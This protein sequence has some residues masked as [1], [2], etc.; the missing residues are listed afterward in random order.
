MSR[1]IPVD[2]TVLCPDGATCHHEC[3]RACFRVLTC[4]PLS[5]YRY[6]G[7]AMDTWPAGMTE[8]HER[9]IA[10]HEIDPD[11]TGGKV[12]AGH[13]STSR[14]AASR[15]RR[16]TQLSALL[17]VVVTA[18]DDGVT[19]FEATSPMRTMLGRTD[20]SRNQVATRMGEL[21]ERGLVT[22]RIAPGQTADRWHY[23]YRYVERQTE[24][25]NTA[26]VWWPTPAGIAERERLRHVLPA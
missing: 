20:L 21:A 4:S 24:G 18:G 12:G 16:G 26:C 9:A 15:V 13:P 14:R 7:R 23:S 6:K 22:R 1:R 17:A 3:E 8:R 11:E 25:E 2:T 10:G 5:D 19:C